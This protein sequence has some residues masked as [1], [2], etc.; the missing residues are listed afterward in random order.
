[1]YLL[2]NRQLVLGVHCQKLR[3]LLTG[4]FRIIFV[5]RFSEHFFFQ[6]FPFLR[7]TINKFIHFDP[8]NR[9]EFVTGN[10][11]YKKS[12]FVWRGIGFF[13]S[14]LVAAVSQYIKTDVEDDSGKYQGRANFLA[15]PQILKH[16]YDLQNCDIENH[17][18]MICII[19]TREKLF[20]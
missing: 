4:I 12:L 5:R 15:N 19:C 20:V 9:Q 10:F 1:M 13:N 2:W 16:S 6:K 8:L 18:L 17:V 11:S 14:I 3:R 7:Q